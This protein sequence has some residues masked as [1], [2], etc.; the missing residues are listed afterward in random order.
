MLTR[1]VSSLEKV[2]PDQ[3][4]RAASAAAFTGF[5][6]ETISFQL[7]YCQP[8]DGVRRGTFCT[9]TCESPIG[10]HVRLRRVVNVP[11]HLAVYNDADADFLRKTPGLYPDMLVDVAEC[12]LRALPGQ[13]NAIWVDVEGA[14]A[15]EHSITLTVTPDDGEPSSQT[16]SVRVLDAELP[17]QQLKYTRW[18]HC[19]AIAQYYHTDMWSEDFWRYLEKFVAAAVRR[20]INTILT[21]IHTPPLDTAVGHERLTS[22]LVDVYLTDGAY[23]FGFER[24]RRFISMCKRCGVRYYEMAHLF[25]QWGAK[26]APKIIVNENGVE[27]AKFGWHVSATSPEYAGFLDAYLP[28]LKAELS[29]Q[30]VLER[31][32]WH[33]SD[34]PSFEHLESYAAARAIAMRHIGDQ[35]VLDALSDVRLYQSGAVEHPV[36]ANNHVHDFIDAQVPGLWTYYCCSQYKGVSNQFIAMPSRRERIIGVQMYKY[37]IEGF[38]HWGYNFYNCQYSYYPIDPYGTTDGDGFVPAGDTFQVYPGKDGEPL[39]SIRMMVFMQAIDDMRALTMLEGLTS[40]EHVLGLIQEG[41]PREMTF[42]DYPR[43]DEYLTSLRERVNAEI[44]ANLRK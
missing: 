29:A 30:G 4:P 3:E 19:D 13:W 44:M 23:S 39:E 31:T 27:H 43:D 22:Q 15:G 38:L 41:F 40:R 25:S 7:A 21:P 36:P 42:A 28:A 18:L 5:A 24:L 11:V 35:Y 2:F 17:G 20:G 1:I 8:D 26:C 9:L 32:I 37:R 14:P 10:A 12:R 6:N 33:I 16:V 34:E